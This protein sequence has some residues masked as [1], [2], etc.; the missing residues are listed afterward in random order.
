[1]HILTKDPFMWGKG[2]TF[3]GEINRNLE[4]VW[5]KKRIIIKR[6]HL[7]GKFESEK[8]TWNNQGNKWTCWL[9]L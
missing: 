2:G 8:K 5:W 7:K 1:M 6:F 4:D 3:L 9:A